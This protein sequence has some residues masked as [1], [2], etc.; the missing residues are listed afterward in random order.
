[1]EDHKESLPA[2]GSV[3]ASPD[4][5]SMTTMEMDAWLSLL[6][7]ASEWDMAQA[8]A[9]MRPEQETH[10]KLRSSQEEWMAWLNFEETETH[11]AVT[12]TTSIDMLMEY[13]TV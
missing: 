2:V 7:D 8:Q 4:D 9:M 3:C 5:W 11:N 12:T 13:I 6:T 10:H 1:M